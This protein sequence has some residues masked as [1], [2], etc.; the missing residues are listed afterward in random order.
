MLAFGAQPGGRAFAEIE[1]PCTATVR[2]VDVT[3]LSSTSAGDAIEVEKDELID[4]TLS[5]TSGATFINHKIDLEIAGFSFNVQDDPSDSDPTVTETIDASDYSDYGVGFYKVS[6]SADL[7]D[8]TT[9][10]GAVLLQIK[11]NPLTTVAGLAAL[12]VGILALILLGVGAMFTLRQF[13][14][15]RRQVEAWG[16]E[17]MAQIN[18][19]QDISPEELARTLRT[20]ARP[21]SMIQF[22][23]LALMPAL[24]LMGAALPGGMPSFG[25]GGLRLPRLGFRPK[26]S[27]V[28]SL[29]GM[30]LGETVTTFLNFLAVQPLTGGGA[31][32]G[33]VAGIVFGVAFDSAVKLWG[34]RDVNKVISRLERDLADAKAR[35]A[36]SAPPPPAPPRASTPPPPPA[37]PEEPP[38]GSPPPV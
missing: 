22:W 18:A 2:G 12:G 37:P 7:S 20:I 25:S 29:G 6:G 5:S 3:D 28:S 9:C 8:G 10:S 36:Q 32:V 23:M 17:Q 38:P 33:A 16:A 4:V 24:L 15:I 21:P 27:F 19:G 1:G 14:A 35:R 34:T 13:R 26:L 11:G 31:V 30:L